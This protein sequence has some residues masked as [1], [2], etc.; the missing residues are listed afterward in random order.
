MCVPCVS[1]PCRI[2]LAGTG[3]SEHSCLVPALRGKSFK[4]SPLSVMLAMGL[5]C[6]AFIILRHILILILYFFGSTCDTWKFPGQGS[7][8]HHSSDPRLSFF[9][10]CLDNVYIIE[11][12]LL[13]WYCLFLPS[14]LLILVWYI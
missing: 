3:K 10:S 8:L 11:S 13:L 12:S 2:T 14:A 6:I 7:N 1:F 4:L 5:S 9:L